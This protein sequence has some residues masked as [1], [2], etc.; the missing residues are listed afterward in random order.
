MSVRI[1]IDSLDFV[2]N[3]GERHGKIPLSEFKRL[4]SLLFDHGGE[5]SFYVAG[6]YDE[7]E[8]PGLYLEIQ[9]NMQLNCQ[10]CLD[11]LS[12]HVDIQ[13]FLL[14]AK[15]ETELSQ[16]DDDDISDAILAA[17]EL[18]IVSLIEDEV[19]LD[20][21]ISVRHPD[22]ECSMH[23]PAPNKNHLIDQ[24]KNKHPFAAL[25]SLKKQIE[26]KE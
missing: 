14:L 19:M 24:A 6:Q 15:N 10:R 23:S 26:P 5:L 11:R 1:V 20:L 2:R 4:H 22:N 25:A 21:S 3:A 18:D 12:Y 16:H 8:R 7:N 9:G 17:P 13:T